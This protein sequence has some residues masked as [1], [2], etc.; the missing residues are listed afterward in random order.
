MDVP[1][2][3]EGIE[4][5]YRHKVKANNVNGK[6]RIIESISLGAL[7]KK[8]TPFRNYLDENRVYINSAQL[9][10]E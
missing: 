8:K 6:M 4:G 9:G 5:Y 10:E 1:G 7:R 3:R 2:G